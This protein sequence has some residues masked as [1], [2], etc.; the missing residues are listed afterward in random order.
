M[1]Q[2]VQVGKDTVS[3]DSEKTYTGMKNPQDAEKLVRKAIGLPVKKQLIYYKDKSDA[4]STVDVLD[5]QLV[6]MFDIKERWYTVEIRLADDS[7]VRIHSSYFAE[8]QRPSF[9]A[10]MAAQSV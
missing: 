10:D 8:M 6:E 5:Y 1:I 7:K 9:I 4:E 2:E 3:L